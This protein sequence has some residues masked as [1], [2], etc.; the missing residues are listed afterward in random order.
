MHVDEAKHKYAPRRVHYRINWNARVLESRN[1]Q[2]TPR[3]KRFHSVF[4]VAW[5]MTLI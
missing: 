1:G 2:H 3:S 4:C 5:Q